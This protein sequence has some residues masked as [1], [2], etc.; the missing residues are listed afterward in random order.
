MGN[1]DSTA[2]WAADVLRFWFQELKPEQW[3]K[4]D[5]A[6][7][8]A[9]VSRFSSTHHFVE[10][11]DVESLL[12]D[13]ETAR[14]A[15]IALDQFSRNMFRGTPRAF[16]SDALAFAVAD[17][18]VAHNWDQALSKP[19]RLFIYLPFEHDE[20]PSS[21][22]RSVALI[23]SLDDELYTKSALA[24]QAIIERFG[25]F[26]HRNEILARTSTPEEIEFLKQPGSSF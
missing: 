14:A 22:Q 18:V 24:H 2:T 25:R 8:A 12:A 26:P 1:T 13:P 5:D 23:S 17:A 15:L 10:A 20:K 4:K 6:V 16:A 11:A 21:Q 3:F 7:D 9:I 19:E